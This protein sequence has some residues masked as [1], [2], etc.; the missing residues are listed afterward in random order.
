MLL[1]NIYPEEKVFISTSKKEILGMIFLEAM[2]LGT[3]TITRLNGGL[4]TI[5]KDNFNG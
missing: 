2:Y 5:I 4:T 1:K 3:L